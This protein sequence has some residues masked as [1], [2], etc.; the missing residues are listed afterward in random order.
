MHGYDLRY[1]ARYIT[2]NILKYKM[3]LLI[4]LLRDKHL[5]INSHQ[6]FFYP[7]SL[8]NALRAPY[9]TLGTP[10]TKLQTR[11]Y[12]CLITWTHYFGSN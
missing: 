4:S 12:A 1:D 3:S 2:C 11:T 9:Q 7:S 8:K 5:Q 10:G 6:T